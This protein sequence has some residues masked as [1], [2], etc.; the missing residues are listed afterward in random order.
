MLKNNLVLLMLY[1]LTSAYVEASEPYCSYQA[2]NL[3]KQLSLVEN[4]VSVTSENIIPHP[5]SETPFK[6]VVLFEGGDLAILEQKNCLMFNLTVDMYFNG[7]NSTKVTLE[8]L[9]SLLRVV[10]FVAKYFE[11]SD[12]VNANFQKIIFSAMKKNQYQFLKK[13]SF[14]LVLSGDIY[15]RQLNSYTELAY[16]PNNYDLTLYNQSLAFYISAGG[17]D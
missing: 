15:S 7:V 14:E 11:K 10:P 12:F 13:D 2:A 4:V 9:A 17:L 8:R 3:S 1:F 16:K 6:H 5:N